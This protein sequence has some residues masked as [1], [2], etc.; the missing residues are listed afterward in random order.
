MTCS[1]STT[2]AA[3]TLGCSVDHV[4]FDFDESATG[5]GG[6]FAGGEEAV[7]ITLENAD[8]FLHGSAQ[9]SSAFTPLGV[10]QGW[11]ADSMAEA[12]RLLVAMGYDYLALGGTVPLK[13]PQIK[14]A[15][16]A[17]RS[18]IPAKTRLH[19]LGFAKAEEIEQ[20]TS[21]G[22]TSFD[23]TSPLIR[24]FK[25]AKSN[26]YMREPGRGMRYYT[27]VRVPQAL[28]NPSCS[29]WRKRVP[30]GR[31]NSCASSAIHSKRFAPTTASR[32]RSIRLSMPC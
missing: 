27:A 22:I 12:A 4:I 20:F 16:D 15:V 23:T 28:E 25:D 18:K 32:R 14:A 2:T 21:S 19:I 11:S 6:S 9:M 13:T 8:A 17:I 10:I 5:L 3:S 26:Y 31:M 30:S 29:S 24:A 7:D 1:G